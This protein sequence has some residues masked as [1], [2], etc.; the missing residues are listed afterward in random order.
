MH[1]TM[2]GHIR[3][4]FTKRVYII[5]WIGNINQYV[6]SPVT[7]CLHYHDVPKHKCSSNQIVLGTSGTNTP[8][9][10]QRDIRPKRGITVHN[11]SINQSFRYLPS[12]TTPLP[13]PPPPP[14]SL[15]TPETAACARSVPEYPEALLSPRSLALQQQP[16]TFWLAL[17][18]CHPLNTKN[19]YKNIVNVF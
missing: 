1:F 12:P 4:V 11:Q 18:S 16:A 6:V 14:P 17:A 15:P 19:K 9:I 13:R 7:K 8:Q 2:H 5:T 10:T 3:M